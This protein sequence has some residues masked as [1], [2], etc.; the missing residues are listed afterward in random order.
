MTSDY[1][2]M[3][4]LTF[5]MLLV[6]T[7]NQTFET[8]QEAKKAIGHANFNRLYKNRQIEFI[9]TENSF[10]IDYEFDKSIHSNS[11]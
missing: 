11:K 5:Y 8:R 4:R 6:K 7:T 1:S 10:A 3:S 2:Q 9:Q